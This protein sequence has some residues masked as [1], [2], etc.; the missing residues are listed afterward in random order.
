MAGGKVQIEAWGKRCGPE[1]DEKLGGEHA[2]TGR[3]ETLDEI[4]RQGKYID[5]DRHNRIKSP[6]PCVCERRAEP[7]QW[8]KPGHRAI[9]DPAH[10]M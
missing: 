2:G 7:T 9:R 6:R 4:R 1:A 5:G 8:S 10:F 3:S